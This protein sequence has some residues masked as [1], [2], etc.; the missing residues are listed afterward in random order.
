MLAVTQPL[1]QSVSQ[2]SLWSVFCPCCV[3]GR[4]FFSRSFV[5]SFTQRPVSVVVLLVGWFH[6]EC[7]HFIHPSSTLRHAHENLWFPTPILPCAIDY[8]RTVLHTQSHKQKQKQKQT[9]KAS[10]RTNERR[11]HSVTVSQRH[12]VTV[13][14]SQFT[15]HSSLFTVPQSQS[16]THSLTHSLT[17]SHSHSLTHSHF[18]HSSDCQFGVHSSLSTF[19]FPSFV[20]S[21]V[22]SFVRSFIRSFVH[23]FVRSFVPSF[24]RLFVHSFTVVTVPRVG[25]NQSKEREGGEGQ[26]PP[27]FLSVTVTV[28]VEGIQTKPNPTVCLWVWKRVWM[29]LR[30]VAVCCLLFAVCCLLFV[31]SFCLHSWGRRK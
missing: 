27:S 29:R 16:L 8:P 31:R 26:S 20:H 23:S 14:S 21:F 6:C 18:T 22:R 9:I 4:S 11:R 15:V 10:K 25:G 24:I 17:V 3:C 5:C 12:S 13:H 19:F 2:C 30:L 7:F 28:T 1:P